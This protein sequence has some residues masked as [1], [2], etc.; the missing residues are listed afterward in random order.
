MISKVSQDWK[1]RLGVLGVNN[2][3]QQFED[4]SKATGEETPTIATQF[5]QEEMDEIAKIRASNGLYEKLVDSIAPAVYGHREVKKGILLMLCGGVHKQ[6]ADGIRLR[7]DLNVAVVGD[8]SV[9]KSQFL[10]YVVS[11]M[12]RSVYTSGLSF[13]F[14]LCFFVS[15]FHQLL[16]LDLVFFFFLI[17]KR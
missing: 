1:V 9:S 11:F 4:D 13:S 5:T 7:G 3:K 17:T 15:F 16:D 6:T 14:S 2:L 12:P 8:P 10:K